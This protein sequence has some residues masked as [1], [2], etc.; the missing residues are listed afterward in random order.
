MIV[1]SSALVS[2]L[3][4]EAGWERRRPAGSASPMPSPPTITSPSERR[5]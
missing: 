1:D 5:R 4:K 3:L 2:L